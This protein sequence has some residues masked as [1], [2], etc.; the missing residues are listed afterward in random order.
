MHANTKSG[1][2]QFSAT[3]ELCRNDQKKFLK[4]VDT[5]L[6]RT[7]AA[8]ADGQKSDTMFAAAYLQRGRGAGELGDVSAHHAGLAAAGTRPRAGLAAFITSHIT[9]SY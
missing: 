1:P 2:G 8:G 5:Y 7:T 9:H 6:S 4:S 3:D